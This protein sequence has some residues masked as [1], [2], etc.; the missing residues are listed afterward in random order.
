MT[1]PLPSPAPSLTLS[2]AHCPAEI[3]RDPARRAQ[4][5]YIVVDV[6]RATTTLTVMFDRGI[7]RAL[8]A[9]TVDEARQAHVSEPTALLAGEVEAVA[10]RDFDHGNSP[11][12]WGALDVTGREVVY[13]TTNGARALHAA[14]GGG[15]IY[16]G[17]LRNASAVCVAALNAA[18]FLASSGAGAEIA[19]VCS[20]LGDQP[21]DDDSLCAGWLI[22]TLRARAAEASM[23]TSLGRG[24]QRALDL[25]ATRQ[26]LGSEREPRE[27]LYDAL[28][29]TPAAQSVIAAGLGADLAWCADVDAS[30][31][32]PMVAG[33]DVARALLIVEQAPEQVVDVMRAEHLD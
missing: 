32:T 33:E 1:G 25:L 13:S 4:T 10:P 14:R 16:A 2:V 22:Q 12:E 9:R 28:N 27:W 18:R 24:A 26:A 30:T 31:A 5:T 11:A 8:V 20:G 29:Q 15:P 3:D 17:A 7:R 21:A 6:I 19:V 23:A